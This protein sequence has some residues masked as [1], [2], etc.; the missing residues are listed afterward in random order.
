[1]AG[2]GEDLLLKI[3]YQS[4][5]QAK[6]IQFTSKTLVAEACLIISTKFGEAVPGRGNSE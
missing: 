3:T 6:K 2:G 5:L 4:G 1:M